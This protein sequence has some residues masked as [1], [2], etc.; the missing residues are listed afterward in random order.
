MLKKKLKKNKVNLIELPR[1]Q[2]IGE[3]GKIMSGLTFQ[4][5]DVNRINKTPNHLTRIHKTETSVV[6]THPS[7]TLFCILCL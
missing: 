7:Y 6:Q 1:S 3:S 5:T 2:P 4:N